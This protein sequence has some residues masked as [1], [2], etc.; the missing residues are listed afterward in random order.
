MYNFVAYIVKHF[1][2]WIILHLLLL[3]LVPLLESRIFLFE[4]LLQV[5]SYTAQG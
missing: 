3:L 2:Q 4:L 5:E 1:Q